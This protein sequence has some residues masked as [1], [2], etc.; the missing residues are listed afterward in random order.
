MANRAAASPISRR[1]AGGFL[2]RA[3]IFTFLIHFAA[4]ILMPLCLMPGLPGGS[5]ATGPQRAAYVASHPCIWRLGWL[6]WGIT[7]LSDL[8]IGIA[9]IRTPW[10]P[11]LPAWIAT[12]VTAAA[13][14]PDQLGQILWMTQGIELAQQAV[15]SGSFEAYLAREATL[16]EWTAAW[17]AGLYLLGAL[18]WTW[19]LAAS[20]GIW[21]R[22]LTVLS[23]ALWSIFVFAATGPLLPPTHRPSG[24]AIAGANA[25]GFVLLQIWF[26]LVA[27][28]VLGHARRPTPFGRYAAWRHPGRGPLARLANLLA[29][30]LFLRATCEWL[31]PRFAY[32]SD[33]TDVIYISFLAP[34]DR[35]AP[36][37]PPGLTLDR[38]G[39]DGEYALFTFLIFR[40][41][42]FGP[43]FL[44]TLRRLMPSPIQSN[45]R[46]HVRNDRTGHRGIYFL[47]TAIT[48]TPHALVARWMAEAMPMH[49]PASAELNRDTD[50]VI[51]LQLKSGGGSAP[52]AEAALRATSDR[53]LPKPWDLC[54]ADYQGFLAYCVPQDR[55]L[56]SQPWSACITRQEIHLGIPLESCEPLSGE[57]ESHAAR[58]I[59]G[60]ASIERPLCFRVPSVAFRFDAEHRDG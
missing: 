15:A 39:P 51:H 36:L 30:S 6:P 8:L 53:S 49:V 33:I 42:H 35:I 59:V 55:A 32:R 26:V 24:A 47:S 22:L 40:H 1:D 54:F 17:G 46:I 44:G 2:V 38:L 13:I 20:P 16:F 3:L 19:A 14:V 27:E 45:W 56:S 21:T 5:D 11:K 43:R 57:I 50:G 58:A 12:L 48:S 9:L 10:I 25:I 28:R 52:D 60:A 34:A 41:G 4:M 37:V 23:I 29:N 18:A 31:V 7:A